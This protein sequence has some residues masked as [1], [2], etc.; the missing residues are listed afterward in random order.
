M[1]LTTEN[2]QLWTDNILLPAIYAQLTASEAQS[3]PSSY[4]MARHKVLAKGILGHIRGLKDTGRR[5]HLGFRVSDWYVER[6]DVRPNI[7]LS[8]SVR[9]RT[10]LTSR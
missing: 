3:L 10:V 8:R 9:T 7:S 5:P 1:N 2:I 4:E 6:F